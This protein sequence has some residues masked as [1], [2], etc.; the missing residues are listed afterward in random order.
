MDASPPLT[1]FVFITVEPTAGTLTLAVQD[2][3]AGIAPE[4]VARIFDAGFTT[5][6]P[7]RGSGIGLAVVSE[8]TRNMFGGTIA[9]ESEVN[10]GSTFRLALPLPSQRATGRI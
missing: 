3:G 10:R 4:H 8:I 1:G 6:A 7:G 2:N 5:K 9:V